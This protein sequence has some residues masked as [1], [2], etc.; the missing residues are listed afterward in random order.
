M[1]V[2]MIPAAGDELFVADLEPPEH[3]LEESRGNDRGAELRV[4]LTRRNRVSMER[5]I[6]QDL[7][8]P[9]DPDA[10]AR[11]EL[12]AED[13]TFLSVLTTVACLPDPDCRFNWLRVAFELGSEL[14]DDALRPVACQLYP[15]RSEDQVKEV[16][17]VE[18]HGDLTVEVVGVGP[19]VGRKQTVQTEA[20]TVRYSVMTFG[21]F[22]PEPTWHFARTEVTPE[23]TGDFFLALVIAVPS[24]VEASASVSLSAQAQLKSSPI[25][26]PV[27][28]RRSADGVIARSFAL[29]ARET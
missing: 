4:M 29:R 8:E 26:I 13:C 28:T 27:L 7:S 18:V 23:V 9:L 22:G 24:G 1:L 14:A 6:V 10:L 2:N 11:L 5:P 17:S 12:P 25:S 20:S 15:M 16:R 19:S 3:L 21:R